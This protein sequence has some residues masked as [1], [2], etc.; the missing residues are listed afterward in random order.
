MFLNRIYYSV[1]PFLPRS[2]RM[3]LRRWVALRKRRNVADIWPIKSGSEQ[4]PAGWPG[5]PE[6]KRFAL[7]LTHDIEGAEGL[8]RVRELAEL[9]MSMGFRSSF[10]FIPEGDYQVPT[11]LRDW[12][13]GNGFEVGVHDLKH[14][15]WLFHRREE[16]ARRARCINQ[17][18]KEWGAVGF[19]AGFMLRNLDWLRELDVA[20]DASTFDTDPFEPQPDGV[21][22]IFPF[23]VP[24][25]P[26]RNP[27]GG[28]K[29]SSPPA[30][31]QSEA[32]YVELP[33]TLAADSTVFLLFRDKTTD[34]WDRKLDWIAQ[35]GGMALLNTHPD[36]M[37]FKEDRLGP[38]Q[39]DVRLYEKFLRDVKSK[40]E[41][42]FW[43]ALPKDVAA[44]AR[45]HR[46]VL[47][48]RPTPHNAPSCRAIAASRPKI[49]I[50]LENTP[51]IPFFKPIIRELEARGYSVVLTA[52]DAFQTCAMA[53]QYGLPYTRIGRHYGQNPLLKL[54]GLV[55]RSMQLLPF[56]LRERPMLGLN[57]GA[58]AQILVC[59]LLRIPNVLIMDY[60]HTKT[61][62]MVRPSWEIVP[63]VVSAERLHCRR[64]ERIRKFAGIKEDV[65]VPE[66]RP[67]S[68]IVELLH[69]NGDVIVTVRPPATEAHY[70]NP[71]AEV[72]FQQ[73]ME[74]VCQTPGVKAVLL[75]RNNTQEAGLRTEY[76]H[77]FRDSK[78]VIPGRVVD[79]LNLLWHSDLAVSGGGTMNREAAAL[80]LPV[81][82]IFRGRIGAVDRSLQGQGRLVLIES[83]EDVYAKIL[84]QRRVREAS[85]DSKPRRALHEIVNHVESILKLHYPG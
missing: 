22:T 74:R 7:V 82:S 20:Y 65:Y 73:F 54:C 13:T 9:E 3:G 27:E 34:L 32:G 12:L 16:F 4:P 56:A 68:S 35:H 57:H 2:L 62:P 64:K 60:E 50:D 28:D 40:Y 36:Y 80:G 41:G 19:R 14:D 30:P 31:D 72:F 47:R 29:E 1:K 75:P 24:A 55:L 21:D 46:D 44:F 77:W 53:T 61:L 25:R 37:C 67:D 6:D 23:W 81:Y 43:H 69:L 70:H 76:P 26:A 83:V 15:G 52:R 18:L 8:A 58:R 49:W 66:F 84:L 45:K 5:W 10:N 59:N 38:N 63:E 78:V 42:Q 71:E 51:H 17:Y 11:E 33:Y 39:F 85:P 79:G 48:L